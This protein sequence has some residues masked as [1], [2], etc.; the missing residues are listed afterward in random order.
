MG[1]LSGIDEAV[2]RLCNQAVANPAFDV[3]M[4]W[5]S[6]NPL[7]LPALLVT[8]ALLLAR[9]GARGRICVV[10]LVLLV[11]VA[12]N[13]SVELLKEAIGRPRPFAAIED[14]RLLVGRGRSLSMPS[15]HA[16]NWFAAVAVVWVYY[17]RVAWALVPVAVGVAF[18]RM[19]NGVHYPSDVLAGAL[20]GLGLGRFGLVGLDRLWRRLGPRAFPLWH[21]QL[22]SLQRP[23][24]HPDPL[25]WQPDL[26]AVRDL[27]AARQ[28]Q[29]LHLGYVLI[30]V[31]LVAR[32]S[33]LAGDKIEL[34]ED[35]AY[36]W[37]WSK[38]LALS[39][40]S[41][42]PMIAWLQALGTGLA[43][44]TAWGVRWL[45]P[46]L[47]AVV[48]VLLLRFLARETNAQTA[49]GLILL[50]TATPLLAGGSIL[51]T[52]DAPL[53]LFWTAALLAGWRA[54][55]PTGRT[56]DWAWAGW[57]VGLAFLS[58]YTALLQWVC[59][60]IFLCVWPKARVHLRRPGPY[61]GVLISL[62]CAAPVLVWNAQHDWITVSHLHDR[63]GLGAVWRPTPNFFIDF[64]L[65]IVALLNPFFF[66]AALA[67]AYNVVRHRRSHPLLMYLFC[68][69]IPL[70]LGH[71]LYTAR[72]RVQP[73]WIAPAVLPLFG[74]LLV[75][76]ETELRAVHKR[77]RAWRTAGLAL[78]LP[79]VLVLHDTNLVGKLIG[80]PLPAR[81]D[82]LRRVRG[83]SELAR[84]VGETRSELL[85]EG[86]PVFIIG[87]HYGI[88]SLIAFYLPEAKAGVPD[89]PLVYALHTDQPKNQFYFW[90][91]Y[92]HRKGENAIFVRH[93]RVAEPAPDTLQ[94]EFASITD[95]GL[96][97]IA[98][99]GRVLH[100]VQLFAC[101]D[102]R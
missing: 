79:L 92:R 86:K 8:A 28:R 50:A 93:A 66:L 19:Y 82:P 31:L 77:W 74:L 68:L 100:T 45:S 85:S 69:S 12:A 36:Q 25:A 9:G 70:L 20:L 24:F 72:A 35:E 62:A 88:A 40:Y 65:A 42:P 63:A 15:G 97:Q 87:G 49:C 7:F 32:W 51:L 14:T 71:W 48:S 44:D 27:A 33:Y 61:L 5:L 78:G 99:R 80:T 34:S 52:I 23:V 55:Q 46:V 10:M 16:A 98:Y 90:P 60:A 47:A 30:G 21:R 73:N 4:P 43:G 64:S 26:P 95:L 76:S 17:R 81:V 89:Q 53:V 59:L 94:T 2:F 84:V 58:K 37:L 1:G 101:R 13:L 22:P 56:R 75:F 54:V 18:S 91:G 83:W 57:W 6:G 39:Y 38:H 3:L 29:W 96:R 67:A 41:K 11:G 102:Q